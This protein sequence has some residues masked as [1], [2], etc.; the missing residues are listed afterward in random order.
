MKGKWGGGEV[1][2]GV[3]KDKE[4]VRQRHVQAK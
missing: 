2:N 1:W 4:E 3:R